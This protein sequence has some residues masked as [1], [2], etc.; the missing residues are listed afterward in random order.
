MG[1]PR[2]IALTGGLTIAAII[3]V[4]FLASKTDILQKFAGGLSSIGRYVGLGVGEGVANIPRGVT[5]GFA[6]VFNQAGSQDPLGL[7]KAYNDWLNSIGIATPAG[8]TGGVIPTAAA[9]LGGSTLDQDGT[10]VSPANRETIDIANYVLNK[11]NEVTQKNIGV[12]LIS[13]NPASTSVIKSVGTPSKPVINITSPKGTT[14]VNY[15]ADGSYAG[16]TAVGGKNVD[17]KVSSSKGAV[18]STIGNKTYKIEKGKTTR[19]K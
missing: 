4:A 5:E 19:I 16:T 7:K 2:K 15:K 13:Y 6:N 14:S 8:I 3:A 10:I 9:D 11:S 18:Y 17:F 12:S 1:L